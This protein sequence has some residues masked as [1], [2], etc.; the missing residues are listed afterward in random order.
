MRSC[1]D[2]SALVC[3]ATR[4]RLTL[5]EWIGLKT[6]LLMCKVC[7]THQKNFLLIKRATQQIIADRQLLAGLP[8]E[9]KKRISKALLNQS[10]NPGR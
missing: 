10:D 3:K 6:H 4:S 8:A 1:K 9:A 5:A 7:R 2:T